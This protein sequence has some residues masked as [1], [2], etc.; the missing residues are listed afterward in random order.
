M[1][2]KGIGRRK[3]SGTKGSANTVSKRKLLLRDDVRAG[4]YK[5][6]AA[7][8]RYKKKG[9]DDDDTDDAHDDDSDEDTDGQDS[10]PVLQL[11]AVVVGKERYVF[12]KGAMVLE[13]EMVLDDDLNEN[14]QFPN[15]S[16]LSAVHDSGK[17]G[18]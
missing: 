11:K 15:N 6:G 1:G 12:G 8:R 17:V 10:P 16:I 18:S 2:R 5:Y 9:T 4:Y 3:K 14:L 7:H 13:E